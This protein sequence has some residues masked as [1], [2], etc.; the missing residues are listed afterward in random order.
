MIK[1]EKTSDVKTLYKQCMSKSLMSTK[2]LHS[3][4]S[5]FDE[6]KQATPLFKPSLL[7]TQSHRMLFFGLISR[8]TFPGNADG[9]KERVH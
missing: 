2:T 8:L 4:K 6:N 3:N 7:N 1:K 9:E 5:A